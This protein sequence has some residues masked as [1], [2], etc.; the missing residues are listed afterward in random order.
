MHVNKTVNSIVRTWVNDVHR[1]TDYLFPG[2]S[3][4]TVELE[5]LTI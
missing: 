5:P 4:T 3:M 1:K 2:N